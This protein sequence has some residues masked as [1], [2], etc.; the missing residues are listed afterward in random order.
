MSYDPKLSWAG[1]GAAQSGPGVGPV[2]N[3]GY[4]RFYDDTEAVPA[5]ADDTN[6]TNG[7]LAELRLG[8]PAFAVHDG[9]GVITA[10]PKT[11]EDSA[12]A[13]GEAT[14]GRYY[15]SAGVCIFQ[16]LC[17]TSDS[18]FI[19]D[20]LTITAT[21]VVGCASAKLRMPRE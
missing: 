21:D 1:V 15:T 8:N 4:C 17:G 5:N 12:P 9:N 19:L 14:Y 3:N 7:L 2:L 10:K 13:G 6:G 16:G 11:P 18:D 20:D